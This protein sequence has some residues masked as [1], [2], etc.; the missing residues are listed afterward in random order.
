MTPEWDL[1]I[2]VFDEESNDERLIKEFAETFE[3][4]HL[5]HMG[6]GGQA[7]VYKCILNNAKEHEMI[8]VDKVNKVFNNEQMAVNKFREMFKEFRIGCCLRH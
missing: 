5:S 8:C 6:S 3:I 2:E 7:D 4:K 1:Q